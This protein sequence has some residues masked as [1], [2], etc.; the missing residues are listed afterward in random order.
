MLRKFL[1]YHLNHLLHVS[2]SEIWKQ[3]IKVAGEKTNQLDGSPSHF[4][5]PLHLPC[6]LKES[7]IR[8]LTICPFLAYLLS[9][10]KPSS[11]VRPQVCRNYSGE[12]CLGFFTG[13]P[14]PLPALSP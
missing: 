9:L 11:M 14:L 10:T 3:A 4:M 13:F 2:F 7:E 1:C 12:S 6:F 8:F 5:L